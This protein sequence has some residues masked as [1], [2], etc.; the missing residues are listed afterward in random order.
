MNWSRLQNSRTGINTII[1]Q[2]TR[3]GTKFSSDNY[4]VNPTTTGEEK[5]NKKRGNAI[6]SWYKRGR[7]KRYEEE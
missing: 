5:G 3:S 4:Q 1:L 6:C 2:L 7:G